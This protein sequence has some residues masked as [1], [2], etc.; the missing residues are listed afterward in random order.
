MANKNNNLVIAY[1]LGTDMAESAADEL[2]KWD[3]E[4]KQIKL[5]AMGVITL[6]RSNGKLEVNEVGQRNTRKGGMW[7]TAIGAALGIASGGLALLPVVAVGAVGGA[8]V[9]AMGH[10]NLGMSDEEH[11]KL[12]EQLRRGGVALG[13]MCDDHEVDATMAE[14]IRHGGEAQL[15]QMPDMTAEA[16]SAA[17]AA[18]KAAVVAVD[19]AA[20]TVEAEAAE[21]A[22]RLVAVEMP[23]LAP[24]ATGAAGKLAAVAGLG[25]AEAGKLFEGGIDKASTLLQQGATPQ[26]RAALAATTGLDSATILGAV[27]KLD[28]M[29]V[30]G[31]GPKSA[32]LLLGSGVDTVM[33]L[34]QRNAGNL[35]AKLHEVNQATGQMIDLPTE[36]EVAG[37]VAQAKELPR[38]VQY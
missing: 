34:A 7:G 33:E 36:K 4:N 6:N 11:E 19:E 16:L 26:G 17:A 13:V 27:K 32:A 1:F 29:R 8:A 31:I 3:D 18:Q 37:W 15:Y 9:G 28:L 20:E 24:E 22:S 38:V 25:A 12:V 2:K 30:K 35:V 21:E 5:G 14:M 23:D 10:K